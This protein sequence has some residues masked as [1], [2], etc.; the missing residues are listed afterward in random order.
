MLEKR[1]FPRPQADRR[2]GRW[3]SESDSHARIALEDTAKR[4]RKKENLFTLGG[5]YECPKKKQT[6]GLDAGTN[7]NVTDGPV[8]PAL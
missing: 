5:Q 3:R 4:C 6:E 7:K 1:G 2:K 8:S